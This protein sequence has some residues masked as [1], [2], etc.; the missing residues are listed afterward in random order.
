MLMLGSDDPGTIWSLILLRHRDFIDASR[1]G[2]LWGATAKPAH[3]GRLFVAVR[4]MKWRWWRKE[5]A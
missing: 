1:R 4:I 3:L 2:G 5:A